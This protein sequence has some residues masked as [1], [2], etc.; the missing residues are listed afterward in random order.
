[1]EKQFI[2]CTVS[3]DC[4]ERGTYQGEV[5]CINSETLVLKKA[6]RNGVPH[7][8]NFATIR[9]SIIEDL[10]ILKTAEETSEPV[11][12]AASTVTVRKPVA[13]RINKTVSENIVG[14]KL[15]HNN[16]NSGISN[17]A[18]NSHFNSNHPSSLSHSSSAHCFGESPWKM[19]TNDSNR[20]SN[21]NQSTNEANRTPNKKERMKQRWSERDEACFGEPINDIIKKDFDFEKNLALF[22]KKAIYDEINAQRPDLVR[23][24]DKQANYRH[25]ES[26]LASSPAQYRQITVPPHYSQRDYVTDDGQ[27]VP[28][29]PSELRRL[30]LNLAEDYGFTF[31]RQSEMLGRAATEI[32]IQLLGGARRLNPRNMHQK[33]L[34]VI[35]CGSNRPGAM[36]LSTARQLAAHGVSTLVYLMDLIHFTTQVSQELSLYKLT[37]QKFTSNIQELPTGAVDLVVMA[38]AD[39]RTNQLNGLA[40]SWILDCRA[41][42]VA[43]DPPATGTPGISVKL[44]IVPTL[45][46]AHCPANGQIYLVNLAIPQKVYTEL[47]IGY[48][49]PFGPKFVIPLHPND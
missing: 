19:Y 42:I 31:E 43:I 48:R 38:L 14:N 5:N 37:G 18:N 8:D 7:P 27:V 3:V 20:L 22:N 47:G 2:G 1:M 9:C 17:N 35:M 46:L 28:T 13:K 29:I 23:Q 25:D 36:G 24:T 21:L 49:S 32:G 34:V 30:L 12:I 41:P 10:K 33:P 6:F 4:G 15:L 40:A 16:A 45:P 44:S 39:E 11:K 26:V